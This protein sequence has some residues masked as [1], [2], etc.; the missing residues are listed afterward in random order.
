MTMWTTL[1]MRH[2][3]FEDV[4]MSELESR[5]FQSSSLF[6]MPFGNCMFNNF[7]PFGMLKF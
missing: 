3:T 6:I 2:G 5:E 4:S 1:K 7:F